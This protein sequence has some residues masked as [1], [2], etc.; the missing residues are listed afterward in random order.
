MVKFKWS[1]DAEAV[2]SRVRRLPQMMTGLM[3]AQ[4][5]GDSNAVI[6]EFQQGL[7]KNTLGLRKLQ[8]GTPIYQSRKLPSN[9]FR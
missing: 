5:L 9:L 6:K 4:T 3:R 2:R 1:K 8:P 7:K